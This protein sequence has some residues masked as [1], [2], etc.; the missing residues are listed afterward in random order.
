MLNPECRGLILRW[1]LP[2]E[3]RWSLQTAIGNFYDDGR[4]SYRD[5]VWHNLEDGEHVE[6]VSGV[7]TKLHHSQ[8]AKAIDGSMRL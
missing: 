6:H 1:T 3:P 8:P 7:D 2:S 4:L 5:A